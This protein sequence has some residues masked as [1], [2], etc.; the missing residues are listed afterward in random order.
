MAVSLSA[1]SASATETEGSPPSATA[2]PVT[3]C[4]D[5]RGDGIRRAGPQGDLVG[6]RIAVQGESLTAS[7]EVAGNVV[8]LF[9]GRLQYGLLIS[10]MDTTVRELIHVGTTPTE[11]S[12]DVGDTTG[13]IVNLSKTVRP[14]LAAHGISITLPID[15]VKPAGHSLTPF[16][17]SGDLEQHHGRNYGD[18]DACPDRDFVEFPD[19]GI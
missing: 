5:R 11:Y 16:E 17:W 18:A 12:V 6:I 10:Y 13:R 9:H 15:Q 7:W 19:L 1:S 4:T 2:K 8:P 14:E 3:A